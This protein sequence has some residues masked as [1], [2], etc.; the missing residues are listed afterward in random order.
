MRPE[1]NSL[2]LEIFKISLLDSSTEGLFELLVDHLEHFLRQLNFFFFLEFGRHS[3]SDMGH[4]GLEGEASK[5]RNI[6]EWHFIDIE[7]EFTLAVM[8]SE[9]PV[10]PSFSIL[11]FHLA[12]V[13]LL[14]EELLRLHWHRVRILELAGLS[15]LK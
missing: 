10:T 2:S 4:V 7:L 9:R 5:I 1:S 12:F 6:I 8:G 11:D 15:K 14:I 3:R 13:P